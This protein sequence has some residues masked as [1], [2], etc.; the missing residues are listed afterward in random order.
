MLEYIPRREPTRIFRES[1]AEE[2]ILRYLKENGLHP[3]GNHSLT[4]KMILQYFEGVVPAEELDRVNRYFRS[5]A[6]PSREGEATDSCHIISCIP[7]K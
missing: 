6:A 5:H 2:L 1:R 4:M 7:R 3:D